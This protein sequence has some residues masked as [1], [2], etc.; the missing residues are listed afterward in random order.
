MLRGFN[1]HS[2]TNEVPVVGCTV[3]EN[4]LR[5][6]KARSGLGASKESLHSLELFQEIP[7]I[8]EVVRVSEPKRVNRAGRHEYG[9]EVRAMPCAVEAT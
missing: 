3:P 2:S 6:P 4:L 5:L 1:L 8:E 9:L 7:R